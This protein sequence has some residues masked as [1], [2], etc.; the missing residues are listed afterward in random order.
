MTAMTPLTARDITEPG[1]YEWLDTDGVLRVG[2]I[3]RESRNRLLGSFVSMDG[4]S[5]AMTVLY[6]DN[7]YCEGTFFGPLPL[8]GA[9]GLAASNKTSS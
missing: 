9:G 8:N 4:H 6:S 5:R 1:A 2:F 3:R 7:H